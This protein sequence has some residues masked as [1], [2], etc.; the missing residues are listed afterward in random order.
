MTGIHA[1]RQ[2]PARVTVLLD[3]LRAKIGQP[4]TWALGV[5]SWR[6]QLAASI[7]ALSKPFYVICAKARDYRPRSSTAAN[8]CTAQST[9]T[10][11]LAFRWRLCGYMM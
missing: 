10:R 9:N 3:A 11:T 4:H 6:R 2:P 5:D 1:L 7:T 8:T